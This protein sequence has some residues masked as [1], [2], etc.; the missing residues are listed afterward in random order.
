VLVFRASHV[1]KD[2]ING[3]LSKADSGTSVA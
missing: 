2:Q 3:T 1:L